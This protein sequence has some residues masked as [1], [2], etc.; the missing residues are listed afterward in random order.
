MMLMTA[1]LFRKCFK[2]K[3]LLTEDPHEESNSPL[4]CTSSL[5]EGV[6][7][8]ID[9]LVFHCTKRSESHIP[10]I[11]VSHSRDRVHIFTLNK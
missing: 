5:A 11:L 6:P 10:E 8:M 4:V 2:I 7:F 9:S 3:K 1:N